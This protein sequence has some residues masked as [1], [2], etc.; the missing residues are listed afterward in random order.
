MRKF[1]GIGRLGRDPELRTTRSGT[2][3]C[4]VDVAYDD[5]W[6]DRK[7][8]MWIKTVA[9]G[10]LAE[11]FERFCHKG[12]EIYADG[13]LET[14]EWTDREGNIRETLK[15]TANDLRFLGPKPSDNSGYDKHSTKADSG[16]GND[17][18]PF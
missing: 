6:G 14:D 8:T 10:K 12:S 2:S 1:T 9:F 11:N 7:T 17:D 15:V 3:V 5:G 13:R 18:V 16:P 4:S